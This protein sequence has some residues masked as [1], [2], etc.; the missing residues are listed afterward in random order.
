MREFMIASAVIRPMTVSDKTAAVVFR[1][2]LRVR[3][4]RIKHVTPTTK[5]P[6]RKIMMKR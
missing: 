4:P 6:Y 2:R 1:L 5:S 3:Q